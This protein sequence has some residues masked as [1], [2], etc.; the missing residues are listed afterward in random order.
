MYADVRLATIGGRPADEVVDS[1]WLQS[2]FLKTVATRGKAII[3]ARGA[4][5]AASAAAA[6]VDHMRD[7][8][9]GTGAGFVSM[10]LPSKGWYGI[11][12]GL[13]YSFPVQTANGVITVKEGLELD[14]F[15]KARL[16]DN[17]ADL[18][19]ERAAVTALLG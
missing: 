7:W 19:E 1:A 2:D 12:E 16:Q 14:E 8:H 9:H 4:S 3:N 6:A 18:E 10:A 17:I 13:V 5:S 11:P 15:A